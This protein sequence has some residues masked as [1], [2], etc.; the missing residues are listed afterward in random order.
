[1]KFMAIN[2]LQNFALKIGSMRK[3]YPH[4]LEF[5]FSTY[6]LWD[7]SV[8]DVIRT[9]M[10]CTSMI[11]VQVSIRNQNSKV[12]DITLNFK[13]RIIDEFS[14][15]FDGVKELAFELSHNLFGENANFID[16][17]RHSAVLYD[18]IIT[19]FLNTIEK[20]A[21]SISSSDENIISARNLRSISRCLYH[22]FDIVIIIFTFLHPPLI[23]STS[24]LQHGRCGCWCG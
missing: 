4:D 13:P 3:T 24:V 12:G 18:P 17:P 6:F 10:K 9:R 5:F 16:T 23:I 8:M 2:S 14:L 15:C 20:I 21:V 19:A 22:Q 7:V 1:M 11:G